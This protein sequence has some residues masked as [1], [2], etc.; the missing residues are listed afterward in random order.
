MKWG[1]RNKSGKFAMI[2]N[3]T[4]IL[5]NFMLYLI[6]RLGETCTPALSI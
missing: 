5:A 4:I 6:I 2:I 1:E 3:Y